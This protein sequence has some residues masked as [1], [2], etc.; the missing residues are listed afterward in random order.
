MVWDMEIVDFVSARTLSLDLVALDFDLP[1]SV[2]VVDLIF[3]VLEIFDV[4]DLFDVVVDL[5]V[6][7]ARD[8]ELQLPCLNGSNDRALRTQGACK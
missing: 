3:D 2:D 1:S 4:V 7:L 5:L 6:E 8:H